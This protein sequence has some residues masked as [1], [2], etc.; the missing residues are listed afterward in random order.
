MRVPAPGS[1]SPRG[2]PKRYVGKADSGNEITRVFCGDC[3]TPLYVQVATRP[4][5]VGIRVATFDDPS[6]F[7]PE[8]DIFVKSAQPWEHLNPASAEIRR[9]IRPD[10]RIK[11]EE[12]DERSSARCGRIRCAPSLMP[13]A[14]AYGTMAF[15][16]FT[17][18]LMAILQAAG[19]DFVLL[20]TEHSG[21]GIETIKAQIAA[22]RGLDIVPMVRVPG[23]HYHLIAPVLDAGAMGIM[24]PMVETAEQA[25]Q[26]A[27]WC[28]YPPDGVRGVAF[29]MAHDDYGGGDVVAEDARCQRS[30]RLVI[31]LVETARGIANVDAIMA[32]DGI[33]VGWLGHFDLTDQHGHSGAIRAPG[34]PARGR[35]AGR[36]LRAQRQA[37]RVPG[38][39]GR[40]GRGVAGKGFRAIAYNTD[41]GLLQESLRGALERLRA[42]EG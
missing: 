37:G 17:P 9:P 41:I 19:A 27:S 10:A 16:F 23:C 24:V 36:R 34:F 14:T 32:V 8:A 20:D 13:A 39:L 5:I 29:G 1:A 26:I 15:E 30:A 7:R 4:D 12:A 3:G 11:P 21:V 42:G 2:A 22:A 35:G 38:R 40:D 33:D 6:W 28:R 25:R 31:A 18:G